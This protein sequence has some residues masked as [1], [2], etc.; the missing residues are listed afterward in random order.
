MQKQFQIV[1]KVK[2]SKVLKYN[3]FMWVEY[4]LELVD[5]TNQTRKVLQDFGKI[6]NP[7]PLP[8]YR[9]K[10]NIVEFV[11]DF[12]F[13]VET[14]SEVDIFKIVKEHL[15]KLNK[16]EYLKIEIVLCLIGN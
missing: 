8:A 7:T 14:N 15:E 1:R 5:I 4:Q 12:V 3:Q 11:P 10:K 2:S 16:P 6:K 13:D 9:N